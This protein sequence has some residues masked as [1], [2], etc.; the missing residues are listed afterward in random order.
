[1]ASNTDELDNIFDTLSSGLGGGVTGG[2]E[3]AAGGTAQGS[4]SSG[5]GST[6][7]TIAKDVLES[8][9]GMV[10]LV[11][12]LLG[13]FGGGSSSP[14]PLVDYQMPDP[15]Q[16]EAADVNGQIVSGD[17]DQTGTARGYGGNPSGPAASQGVTVSIQAMD[18]QSFMDRSSDI[19]AAVK[20]AMLNLNSIN[21]VVNDL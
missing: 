4:G 6:L 13:L 21:D 15:I 7:E 3:E 5:G 19:A 12:G 2:I 18:A 1:M 17:Y 8:G 11:G 20:N 10:P 16:Y 14:P 9:L